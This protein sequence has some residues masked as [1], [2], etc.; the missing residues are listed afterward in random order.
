VRAYAFLAFLSAVLVTAASVLK[1]ASFF[2][3]AVRL[4]RILYGALLIHT[5]GGI[6]VRVCCPCAHRQGLCQVTIRGLLLIQEFHFTFLP[7]LQRG[8]LWPNYAVGLRQAQN[9]EYCAVL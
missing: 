8:R 4:Q 9:S 1:T 5:P 7:Y 6:D 3:N 2:M